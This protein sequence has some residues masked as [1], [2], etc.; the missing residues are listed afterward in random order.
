MGTVTNLTL[1]KQKLD[2][3]RSKVGDRYIMKMMRESGAILGGEPSGH[4]I[5][6]EHA[7]TGDEFVA[8]KSSN[9]SK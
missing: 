3:M 2:F 6:G 9:V 1:K 4:I 5:L 8:L 7:T